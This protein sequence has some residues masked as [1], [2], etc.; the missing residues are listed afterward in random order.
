MVVILV[1]AEVLARQRVALVQEET[2]PGARVEHAERSFNLSLLSVMRLD[3]EDNL[4]D[5]GRKRGSI[6]ARHA[7]RGVDDDNAIG[8]ALGHFRH[9]DR[10]LPA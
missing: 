10:H 9:Q 3:D 7:W 5:Q 2:D 4:S 8:K 6:A 1:R